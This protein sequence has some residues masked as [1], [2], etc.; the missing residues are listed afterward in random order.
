[1][2]W[3]FT[4]LRISIIILLFSALSP[5]ASVAE[6]KTALLE[7]LKAG[8]YEKL[9]AATIEL[10]S[11]FE[12]GELS[13]IELRNTY[14]QFYDL[15]RQT[16]QNLDEWKRKYPDSYS[17]HLIKGTFLKRMGFK[18]RGE[19]YISQTPKQSI[20]TMKQYH[21][22]AENELLASL[23]LTKKPLLSI[24]HLLDICKARGDRTTAL[25]LEKSA[26]EM[27]SDNT[28]VRNRYFTSLAPRWGGSYEEMRDFIAKTKA[29]GVSDVVIMQL[30]AVMYDDMGATL[31]EFGKRSDAME[32]FLKALELGQRVGGE[33]RKDWLA[34]SNRFGCREPS[35]KEYC[36]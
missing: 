32:Y 19:N 27:L 10:Q 31:Y 16:L 22:E 5:V 6:E 34:F 17:A 15:N 29:E 13:E 28:L 8:D 20:D 23:K 3:G 12:N 21:E 36:Q 18:I 9:E 33:F 24:F 4:I 14:R 30:E 11:E 26:N 2:K 7:M 35:L 1:M 25:A